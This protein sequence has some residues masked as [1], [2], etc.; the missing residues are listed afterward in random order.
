[1]LFGSL[2]SEALVVTI[3]ENIE[4]LNAIGSLIFSNLD[5]WINQMLEKT[6]II[7]SQK[8]QHYLWLD[9]RWIKVSLNF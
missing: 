9:Q 6:V 8:L 5:K 1:M 7:K 3:T 2:I 4:M